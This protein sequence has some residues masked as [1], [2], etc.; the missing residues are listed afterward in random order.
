MRNMGRGMFFG[1]ELFPELAVR[2]WIR[3]LFLPFLITRRSLIT[4]SGNENIIPRVSAPIELVNE[5]KQHIGVNECKQRRY[6]S[7]PI[8]TR[9]FVCVCS[10]DHCDGI[11]P[12]RLEEVSANTLVYYT[13][14]IDDER[15]K[16]RETTFDAAERRLS[17]GLFATSLD[18]SIG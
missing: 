13:S 7:A 16:R 2:V 6:D 11:E 8:T 10:G 12:L 15:F 9:S 17:S 3:E 14:T 1:F 4:S 18:N 5:E